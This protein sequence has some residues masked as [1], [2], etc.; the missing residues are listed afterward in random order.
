MY[1]DLK[2]TDWEQWTNRISHQT[3][4]HIDDNLKEHNDARTLWNTLSNIIPDANDQIMPNYVLHPIVSH[5]G[6]QK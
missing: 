2:N 6:S 5:S 4:E 1:K 3:T